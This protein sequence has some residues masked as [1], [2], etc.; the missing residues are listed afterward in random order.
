MGAQSSLTGGATPRGDLLLSTRLLTRFESLTP[1]TVR[2]G[3]GLTLLDLQNRLAA[4]RR[5]FPPVPTFEGAFVGGTIATNAAGAATF[6]YGSTRAWVL[7]ATVVLADGSIVD[8]ERGI[9]VDDNGQFEIERADGRIACVTIPTYRMPAVAKHSG[10]YYARPGMDVLDLFIGSEG[11]LG[12]VVEATLRVIP[13]PSGWMALVARTSEPQALAITRALRIASQETWVRGRGIDVA[14]VEYIDATALHLIEADAWERAQMPRPAGAAAALLLVQ[15]EAGIE[16]FG[17]ILEQH[18]AADDVVMASREDVRGTARLL[19]LREAVPVTVNR[20]VAAA[21][22]V[23]P[24]IEKTA[25]DMIVPFDELA[26]SL[27]IYREAFHRRGLEVAIWGHFSDGNLHP[28]LVPHTFEDVQ[29]GQ[30]AVVEIAAGIIALGGSPLAEHGVG[31]SR[32][33]QALLRA[34]YGE[35]GINQMRSVKRALDPEWKLADGVIFPRA[36]QP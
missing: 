32:V 33:K 11:T 10:G 6:K 16:E 3:A 21:K 18:G 20:R 1:S 19:E 5:W 26:A 25:A 35:D 8:L 2:A 29:Q 22:A 23:E 28:N 17:T 34:L 13:R 12:I 14:G 30:D 24:R 15:L 36:T 31:R 4:D 27:G 9:T 7:A